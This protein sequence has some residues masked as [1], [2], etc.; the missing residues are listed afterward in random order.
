MAARLGVLRGRKKKGDKTVRRNCQGIRNSGNWRYRVIKHYKHR[1]E[2]FL[3]QASTEAER[4]AWT[5][6]VAWFDDILSRKRLSHSDSLV[7]PKVNV[8]EVEQT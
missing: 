8:I 7:I 3:E 6:V 5:K 2:H 1:A 4:Q